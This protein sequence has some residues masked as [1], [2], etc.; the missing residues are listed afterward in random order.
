MEKETVNLNAPVLVTGATGYVGGRLI[1]RLVEEGYTVRAMGR[2][3]DKMASRPWAGL[4]G[5][6]IVEGDVLDLDSMVEAGRG[7]QAAYYLVHAM[8]AHKG[9]FAQADR[10]SAQNMRLAAESIGLNQIIYLGGLG[11]V[12]HPDLSPHLAS[13]HEVGKI[14]QS[15]PVPA[16]VLR[17]AMILG[18]GS[19]SFEILRYLVERLPVML[20]P[21]WVQTPTQP[22]A[23]SNVIGYLVGCLNNAS[24]I[25]G[26]FDIGGPEV[27]TYADLI[28]IYAQEAGLPR[29]W[30]IAVPVLTPR[31]S[32]R[33]IH[34][35]TPVPASIALPLTE[36]LSVP[37]T[38]EN[39]AIRER[40]PQTLIDCRQAVRLALDS[41]LQKQVETCWTDAG[42]LQSPEWAFRGDAAYAGG[43]ILNCA[44]RLR[45]NAPPERIWQEIAAI[46]GT[47]GYYFG[48]ALWRL[49][50]LLD[51]WAGGV[52]FA[53]GRRH[54]E[55][56]RVGDALDFW[57]VLNLAP[58]RRLTLLSEMRVPGEAILEW[59]IHSLG[60]GRTELGM[61]SRFLPRGVGGLVYWYLFYPAHVWMFKGMLTAIA[62]RLGQSGKA[63]VESFDPDEESSCELFS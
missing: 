11:D 22:I 43:T 12:R 14:L 15:G 35:V 36:G 24:T 30:V 6:Q 8:M 18:S 39:H 42:R 46:G 34:L 48:N 38:C 53:R 57:R 31:L 23:I 51:R 60:N 4:P 40:V 32:A 52:G 20:T 41:I 16:T 5:V 2:R 56:L 62:G 54:P 61:V 59:R 58:G 45:V 1:P 50:G 9:R 17:A 13:R 7:C 19:A 21:R 26:S 63:A 28:R 33:W 25:G 47:N 29:R 55:Q 37:T 27:L 44:Y 49:R 3:L 10:Q